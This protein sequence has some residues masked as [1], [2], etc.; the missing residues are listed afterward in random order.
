MGELFLSFHHVGSRNQTRVVRLSGKLLYVL[1]YLFR[2]HLSI[3]FKEIF[4]KYIDFCREIC[5][6]EVGFQQILLAEIHTK[7]Y[8]LIKVKTEASV[9]EP[10]AAR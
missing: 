6:V 5:L 2:P 9:E 8:F 3:S 10:C 4:K 7:V 1:S